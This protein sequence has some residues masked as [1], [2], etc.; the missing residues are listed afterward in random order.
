MSILCANGAPVRPLNSRIQS[1][2]A[3][4]DLA[5]GRFPLWQ[6]VPGQLEG[7]VSLTGRDNS[8]PFSRIKSSCKWGMQS[9]P[10]ISAL[11]PYGPFRQQRRIP[12]SHYEDCSGVSETF[13]H[14][15]KSAGGLRPPPTGCRRRP[16]PEI[17]R[18]RPAG[19][20]DRQPGHRDRRGLSFSEAASGS[21]TW[22]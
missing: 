3:G 6:A 5:L 1:E 2:I 22:P 13:P 15:G 16:E 10:R 14:A 20:R 21:P 17:T 9:K 11:P 7:L 4:I 19:R 12:R 8:T 18:W